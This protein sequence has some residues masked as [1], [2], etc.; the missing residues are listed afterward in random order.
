MSFIEFKDV[1]KSYNADKSVI[2]SLSLSID[3]GELV[4]ILGP[5]GCGKTTLLKMINGLTSYNDG[6]IYI[7]GK[8]LKEWNLINLRRK[9]GYVVQQIG[10]FPHLTVENNITYVLSLLN[11]KNKEKHLRAKELIQLV[12][13]EDTYLNRYPR[14]LSGGQKQRIGVARALAA[15]P[16]IVLMDEPFG[17]IDEITRKVMQ[18]ELLRLHEKLKKTIVFVTHDIEEAIKLGT[19]I[20]LMKDGEIEQIGTKE[21]M[22]FNPK[23][24]FVKEF[25]GIKGFNAYL[26]KLS[27]GEVCNSMD[28]T[29]V[30]A[31][32]FRNKLP[33]ET[34][35]MEAI[36]VMI[37]QKVDNTII[38]DTD[39]NI[40]GE[41]SLNDILV[42]LRSS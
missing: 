38:I 17:A 4:T 16:D 29:K 14:E 1:S 19:K 25:I 10:L 22:I 40:I 18:E 42:K 37:E 8:E 23:N 3:K 26:S 35:V 21:E 41:F 13:L 30:G 32:D 6:Q 33:K 20:L 5:S 15:N 34:S 9:I 36:R 11:H 27:I 28:N 7:L 31:L 2:S 24:K 39:G 12:G